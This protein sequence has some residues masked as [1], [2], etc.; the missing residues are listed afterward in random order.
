MPYVIS[1][2]VIISI[3]LVLAVSKSKRY[4]RIFND[5]HYEE[6]ANWVS[7]VL[8]KHPIDTSSL[9][10][11][12]A[13]ITTAGVILAYTS[14][15]N[16]GNRS[17]HFSVSQQEGYTTGA[18]GG[19][20]LF[21]ILR[22]LHKN[23]CTANLYTTKSTVHHAEFSMADGLEWETES[24]ELVVADMENYRPLPIEFVD[25]AEL[26]EAPESGASAQ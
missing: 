6:I 23:Q 16:S 9:E 14:V 13:F 12:T 20:V 1:I 11:G 17:V 25:V 10:E 22:M 2:V 24:I 21:L 8:K 18:V 7:I 4:N 3:C 15:N 26:A 19:R 5:Q